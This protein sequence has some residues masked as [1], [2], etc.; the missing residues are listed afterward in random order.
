M[1][2]IGVLFSGGIESSLLLSFYLRKG[3]IVY[4]FYV[5]CGFRWER[6]E[7][8]WASRLWAFLKKRNPALM[9]FKVLSFGEPGRRI[10]AP[11]RSER[12]IEIPLRNMTLTL[13]VVL[14]S[15]QKGIKRIAIGSLGIYPFPDNNRDFF[16]SL[17]SLISGAVRDRV[18]IETPFMGLHKEEVIRREGGDFP[19]HLT[20]SCAYPRGNLHCGSCT[21]C[22]ERIEGFK[23]AG[24]RDRTRYL[25]RRSS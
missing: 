6:A 21:K 12:D 24:I 25:F 2:R 9:T 20:F 7:L 11:P 18:L 16:D 5:K 19:L 14:S 3:Y 17:Q 15:M 1:N 8:R 22:V 23:R 13:R 4:P 10:K